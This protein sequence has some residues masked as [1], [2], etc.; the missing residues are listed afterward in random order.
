M[1]TTRVVVACAMCIAVTDGDECPAAEDVALESLS[2]SECDLEATEVLGEY[3]RQAGKEEIE[4]LTE[5]A[6]IYFLCED[7]YN[8]ERTIR[9]MMRAL[10]SS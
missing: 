2:A 1:T 6:R 10:P 7:F 3:M 4:T 5:K 9:S 8:Y